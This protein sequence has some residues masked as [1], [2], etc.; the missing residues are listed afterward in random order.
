MHIADVIEMLS[1]QIREMMS[2]N[3]GAALA[4]DGGASL[5]LSEMASAMKQFP[6]FRETMAKLSQHMHI[7]HQCMDKFNKQ[8]LL[9]LSEVSERSERAL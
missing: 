2:N 5:S 9:E 3:S 1:S 7:S 8:N 6:E 4:K